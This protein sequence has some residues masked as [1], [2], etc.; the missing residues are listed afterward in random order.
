M[1]EIKL[2]KG[3][4]VK[5]GTTNGLIYIVYEGK[6]ILIT[7]TVLRLMVEANDGHI[8]NYDIND[9]VLKFLQGLQ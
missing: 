2:D 4:V 9:R 8:R 7:E 5:S 1:T 3:I 6:E